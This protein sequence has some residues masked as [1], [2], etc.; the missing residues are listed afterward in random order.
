MIG[1]LPLQSARHA[2]FLHNEVPGIT[3][4]EQALER[5]RA[6]GNHGRAVGVEMARELLLDLK[7]HAQGV[8]LMPSFGRYEVAAEVLEGVVTRV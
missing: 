3:L 8:Y 4:T 2:E 6:A 1:I 5:M 7:P